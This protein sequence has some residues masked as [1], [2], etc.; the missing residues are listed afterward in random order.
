MLNAWIAY[1]KAE[2]PNISK[3]YD[4]RV[5]IDEE[6]IIVKVM[7]FV[8]NGESGQQEETIMLNVTYTE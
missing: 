5:P 8:F 6:N 1:A 2:P 7:I 3:T 4:M